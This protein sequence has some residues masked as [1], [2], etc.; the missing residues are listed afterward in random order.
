[1][2][3][4]QIADIIHA[5]Q[6]DVDKVEHLLHSSP[7]GLKVF[8]ESLAVYVRTTDSYEERISE[9]LPTVAEWLEHQ[10]PTSLR[11]NWLWTVQARL[12]NPRNLIKGLTRDWVIDRLTEGYRIPV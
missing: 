4:L 9:L 3:F 5:A 7:A 1:M 12:G 11:V 8:H 2:A 6:P 10:A